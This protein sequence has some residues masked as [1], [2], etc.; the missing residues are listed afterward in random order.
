MLKFDTF[1]SI[2]LD[3]GSHVIEFKFIP[4]GLILGSII[5]CL[6]IIT[7]IIYLKKSKKKLT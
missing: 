1:I 7:L 4:R 6:S 5:S 2:P 3:K